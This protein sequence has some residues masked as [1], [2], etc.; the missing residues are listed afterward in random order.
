MK[1]LILLLISILST[2]SFLLAQENQTSENSYP[3]FVPYSVRQDTVSI[4]NT[5]N[6]I[7][8]L[9]KEQ[10]ARWLTVDPLADK[11]PGW[12]PYNYTANN[13][14]RFIDPNGMDW[15]D[16]E[17]KIQ[18]RDNEGDLI[19]N[20]ITYTSLG[21]NILV[22][23]H[24]RDENGNEEINSAI[25]EIYLESNTEGPTATTYGNTIPADIEKYG[26]LREGLYSASYQSRSKYPGEAAIIINNGG[27]LPTVNGNPNNKK[28]N[29][30]EISEHIMN[31]V[32]FHRG[33]SSRESLFTSI[34]RVIS[35]GCQ[36]GPNGKGSKELFNE[37][38]RNVPKDFNGNYYLRG[39]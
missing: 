27:D 33:N 22:G 32:F 10:P 7:I 23:Y 16:I 35:A 5:A 21:K 8:E 2:S 29:G 34:G 38:M 6:K 24:N 4:N 18:W 19:E 39:K 20:D 3:K 13:P 11:Y 17:G 14:L 28:N 36:T 30:K 9:G 26:T 25:F 15:Y 1:L 37:F 12:S 31:E